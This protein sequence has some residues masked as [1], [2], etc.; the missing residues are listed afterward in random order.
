MIKQNIS[1][2][3]IFLYSKR[4]CSEEC[5]F[6]MTR[7]IQSNNRY[8][9]QWK[10]QSYL[11]PPKKYFQHSPMDRIDTTKRENRGCMLPEINIRAQQE[12]RDQRLKCGWSCCRWNDSSD[13]SLGPPPLNSQCT[14]SCSH[15]KDW[16]DSKWRWLKEMNSVNISSFFYEVC[17]LHTLTL[18]P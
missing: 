13:D 7:H 15:T 9:T 18:P 14:N 6:L 10:K 11:F 2:Q 17:S 16:D 12:P 8:H 4:V 1:L 5:D 3:F